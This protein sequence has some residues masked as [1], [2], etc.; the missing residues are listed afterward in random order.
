MAAGKDSGLLLPPTAP[1]PRPVGTVL[2]MIIINAFIS[3]QL[4]CYTWVHRQMAAKHH[5]TT[6][7]NT[8]TNSSDSID[9]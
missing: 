6:T 1:R 8:K 7:T 5:N 9:S 4:K 3:A 2:V